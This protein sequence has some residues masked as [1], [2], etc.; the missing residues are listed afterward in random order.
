[1]DD[2]LRPTPLPSDLEASP[3]FAIAA[4]EEIEAVRITMDSQIDREFTPQTV[5]V[6]ADEA[7]QRSLYLKESGLHPVFNR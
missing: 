6:A 3:D 2:A 5:T 7:V 4:F 1:M